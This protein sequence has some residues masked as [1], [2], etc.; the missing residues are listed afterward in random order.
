[1]SGKRLFAF[2]A[3]NGEP[4]RDRRCGRRSE[5]MSNEKLDDEDL[6]WHFTSCD[7]LSKILLGKDGLLA[8]STLFMDDAD[9]CSLSRRLLQATIPLQQAIANASG[10]GVLS[11]KMAPKYFSSGMALPTFAVSFTV[12]VKNPV[13]WQ[14]HTKAGGVSIG[15]NRSMLENALRIQK[16]NCFDV[17]AKECEYRTFQSLARN[18]DTFE[19]RIKKA[20]GKSTNHIINQGQLTVFQKMKNRCDELAKELVFTKKRDLKWEKEFR[21]SY[22]CRNKNLLVDRLRFYN[23]KPFVTMKLPAGKLIRDFV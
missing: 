3:P 7:A 23:G 11:S 16:D 9:D 6:L 13:M 10:S 14:V 1:M 19:R 17:E 5:I 22:V 12:M 20:L 18:I 15:F 2:F 21:I 8:G 4:H